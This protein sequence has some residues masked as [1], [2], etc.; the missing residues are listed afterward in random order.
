MIHIKT[1][2]IIQNKHTAVTVGKFDGVHL[3]HRQLINEVTNAATA[4]SISSVVFSFS[5][6]PSVFFKKIG[7]STILTS[8]EK[9][10]IINDLGVDIFIEY[11]FDELAYMLPEDFVSEVL[12][13]HLRAK[14]IVVGEDFKFGR[15]QQG[16]CRLL[17]RVAS[18][19]GVD[20]KILPHCMMDGEKVSSSRIRK[21]IMNNDFAN[22]EA[23]MGRPY[24]ISGT[25]SH[26]KKL[27]RAVIG[28]P[29]A[30][31]I[32]QANKLICE[33]G[34]YATKAKIGGAFFNSVTS[35]G[36]NPTVKGEQKTV[37]TYI[38]DFDKNIY[39]EEI[40]VFFY[41]RLREETKF[42][43]IDEL[44]AQIGK[45]VEAAGAFFEKEQS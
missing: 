35:I 43:S 42:G 3:G 37:E 2:Q 34:V 24:F 7:H 21:Y 32:P 22:A 38:F 40:A 9:A 33:N 23:Y 17:A 5:Q 19:K 25:V 36:F 12:I 11:P 20:V 16:D 14:L 41:K 18:E 39:G 45:D 15:N 26:G 27:G 29:T 6:P 13:K 1:K 10:Y 30:N 4:Q 44:I 31:I 28:Y 8:Q